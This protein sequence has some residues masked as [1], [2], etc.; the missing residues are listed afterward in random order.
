MR[1]ELVFADPH[2]P[3]HDEKYLNVLLQAI[4]IVKPHTVRCVGD[5]GEWDSV[6]PWQFKRRKRPPLEYILDALTMEAEEVNAVLDRIDETCKS[7]GVKKK[8]MHMGNHEI[9]LENLHEEHPY[10]EWVLPW[11]IMELNKRK[12]TWTPN[13]KLVNVEGLI[14]YH[15][16]AYGGIY[17]GAN[18]LRKF[19]NVDIMYGHLHD[20]QI[21][22][23][24]LVEGTAKAYCIGCGKKMDRDSNDWVGP[25]AMNWSHAF[26]IASFFRGIHTVEVVEVK[27]GRAT[28]WGHE[29]NGGTN[30]TKK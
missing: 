23:A 14:M 19:G 20:Y 1:R 3:L 25:R 30:G 27:D 7:A 6:S 28:L 5:F 18:N 4:E 8:H 15:G 12:W 13:H 24:S 10:L 11:H 16:N 26:A 17:H 2:A 21:H 22:S 9:W 29:L